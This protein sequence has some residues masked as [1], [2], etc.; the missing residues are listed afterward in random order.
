MKR[1][2]IFCILIGVLMLMCS[3][4]ADPKVD[5]DQLINKART[6]YKN[7]DSAKVVITNTETNE[8]EQTFEF[9]YDEKG[10]LTYA[11]EGKNGDDVYAEYNNGVESYSYE[12]GE[13]KH[14]QKGD[15][16]FAVYSKDVTHP[17]AD[18]GL[19]LF[20]PKAVS[21]AKVSDESGVTHIHHDYNVD[22]LQ[23]EEKP[24][25]FSVD[26]YFDSDDNL[27]YF[28]ETSV[29]DS[30]KHSYKV[31]ITE[32]NSVDKVENTAEKFQG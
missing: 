7:L 20:V 32:K 4:G 25:E 28:I 23:T 27:L 1:K 31:E 8:A 21:E 5:G 14:M 16:S 24:E 13:L 11:Y 3:C 26:Y 10:F 29:I 2:A 15:D 9:K 30:Q 22:K 6:D 18:E 17:Q 19:I 12:N